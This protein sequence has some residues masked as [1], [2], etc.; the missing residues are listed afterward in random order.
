MAANSP[1][2]STTGKA[3]RFVVSLSC[4]CL[5]G[6]G[7]NEQAVE[8]HAKP[9][10][11]EAQLKTPD[12]PTVQ[13][14]AEE[15][16][17]FDQTVFR[18]EVDA[19]AYESAF[20]ALWD[21]LRSTEPFTVLRQFPFIR[22]ELPSTSTWTP[23][24]LGVPGIRQARLDGET[25]PLTHAAY[26]AQLNR[27]QQA[28]WEIAQTE[29]H[30]SEFRP[31][32][33]GQAPESIVS[34]EIH[35]TN[36]GAKRRAIVKGQLEVTWTP[37]K[38]RTGLR[39]PGTI[40]VLDTAITDR[41][42]EPAF[43]ELLQIDPKKV[44]P[45]L[46]PRVSPLIVYDLDGDGPPEIL[47]AGCNLVYRNRGGGQ[48]EHESWLEHPIIPLG[49]A[50][51]LSDF[52]GDGAVDFI[53]TGKE[54]G[55]LRLWPGDANGRFTSRPRVCFDS[56]YKTPHTMTAADIDL[57]GDLDLFV[58][59]W[60]QPYLRGSMPTPYYDANDGYP[61]TLLLNNGTG[62]FTDG[63][64]AAGLG[65]KRNRRT[66]S[67]SFA[68]LDGDHDLDLLTVCDFSGIDLYR[69]DGRGTYTDVTDQWVRQR[70][71]FGMSHAVNDFDGDGALDIYMVGMSSTTARRLDRLGLGRDGFEK[72]DAMRAPMTYGNRLFLGGQGGFRQPDFGDDV[73]RTGWSWGCGSA[74][75]DNDGDMDLYVANGHL[76]GNS[77]LDYC[78][79]FWCHDVYTGTSQPNETLDTFF[80]G[81]LQGLGSR[82]SWNGF[83]HNHLFLN[84]NRA[85]FSNAAF[86]LGTA[87]E[88][89][90]R[91]V[92]LADVDVDGRPDLLVVQYDAKERQQRLFVMRNQIQTNGNWIGLHIP[93]QPGLPATGAT[94]QLH[95]GNRND[96]RQL[97]TGDSF[98]AQHPATVHFGLG[99]NRAV[100]KL[101]IRWPS[102]KT[103]TLAQ[104]TTGQYHRLKN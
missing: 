3:A 94:I 27:L 97:V 13:A 21:R 33:D 72:L 9:I 86:L 75:F 34:F 18:H 82:Y 100:D 79:R 36:R 70:H 59:Q 95:T 68:D 64:K 76:S 19:Q 73:A 40:R 1:I 47:L 67:A 24:P 26:L 2:P 5:L 7:P 12:P 60:K 84:R 92:V 104:P 63:T 49:E 77:A 101:V 85:G 87:F 61:D 91:S 74:D 57:D 37:N 96:V 90:A 89:D 81:T 50:G 35:A 43:T 98:T 71:G 4:L 17:R 93:D 55:L 62:Q 102:G 45:K 66:Y 11:S 103:M 32:R 25:I 8:P 6:C 80:S 15:Q 30:H 44:D 88:F 46:Y 53:S 42:G 38:T 52:N 83:E 20:V 54:D 22:L 99:E 65:A 51:I 56:P 16:V 48:F 78:T 28:G 10:P 29:W 69:N 58:G 39:I 41:T 14:L 31:S 23:M